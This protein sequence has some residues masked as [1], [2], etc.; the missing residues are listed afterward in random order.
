MTHANVL[1]PAV[2]LATLLILAP[3]A[4]AVTWGGHLGTVHLSF[5]PAPDV[6]PVLMQEP[7]PGPGLLVDVYAVMK[8]MDPVLYQGERVLAAGGFEMRLRV[9]GADDAQVLAKEVPILH[10]DVAPD[11][12]TIIC[13][14]QPDIT[15][16]D[17]GVVLAKWR[18]RIPGETAR[19]VSFHLD[20]DGP[21]SDAGLEGVKDA[22]VFML[23]TG[24]LQNRQ[25]GLMFAAGYVPAWLNPRD[26]PDLTPRHGSTTWQDTGLF[27][28]AD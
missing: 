23:W 25:H 28:R 14:L 7:E 26:D 8:D 27:T 18:V 5:Q 16:Q 3:V 13:G 1:R 19:P 20:P 10:L 22:G 15:F 2:L 17:G 11:N 12:A 4:G 21:R 6:Q 24:S 9:D